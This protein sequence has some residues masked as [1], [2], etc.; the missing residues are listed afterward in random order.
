VII[1]FEGKMKKYYYI[2]I[3]A[4]IAITCL[5][6]GYIVKLY[7]NY[8]AEKIIEFDGYIKKALDEELNIRI[9][10]KINR[11]RQMHLK[12]ISNMTPEERDSIM[13]P[14]YGD[15]LINLTE[16]NENRIGETVDDIFKQLEQDQAMQNGLYLNI[17]VLDSILNQYT[18]NKYTY[19]LITYDKNK[20]AIDSAGNFTMKNFNYSSPLYP[21]GTN[22]QLFLQG[23]VLIPMSDFIKFQFQ[24]LAMSAFLMLIIL[25]CL[26]YQLIEIRHKNQLLKKRE[27]SVNGTIHDLKTPLNSIITMLSWFKKAEKDAKTN[28]IIELCQ[29]SVKHMV[30]NIESLLLT[31]RKDK[32]KIILHKNHI[33]I[34]DLTQLV[35]KELDILFQSKPHTIDIIDHL[36]ANKMIYADSMY[37][38]NV[39]RNLIENS[40]KYSDDGVFIKITLSVSNNMF[41][42]A[43]HDNGW[44]IPPKYQRK[45]FTQFYQVPRTK[46]KIQKG[47]GI[48]LAHAKNII[49][50]H[51][52]EITIISNENKGSTFSFTIPPSL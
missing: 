10:N 11:T 47:Y 14:A 39:I 17:T 7:D 4:S 46:D 45:L 41:N 19:N 48:G 15:T 25:A 26:L 42:F 32:Q 28:Q 49:N 35:K 6:A 44:G 34:L 52:G 51:G 31:A 43:I 21:I 23:K 40:L 30:Y 3:I 1:L 29:T 37:L 20:S 2:T 38:E 16:T 50:A 18:N 12:R 24:V 22:S 33:N 27:T 13:Q 36:P 8:I 9:H 5:Q